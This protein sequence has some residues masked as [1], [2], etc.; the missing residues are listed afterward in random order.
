MGCGSSRPSDT[1]NP[2]D[3]EARTQTQGIWDDDFRPMPRGPTMNPP[4][5]LARP[6]TNDL[7]AD[8]AVTVPADISPTQMDLQ[9]NFPTQTYI[10]NSRNPQYPLYTHSITNSQWSELALHGDQDSQS[11]KPIP[12]GDPARYTIDARSLGHQ[13]VFTQANSPSEKSAPSKPSR[14]PQRPAAP[15]GN[16][17]FHDAYI[18]GHEVRF[19]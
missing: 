19:L 17:T 1:F 10:P 14:D 15:H 13:P 2:Q 7:R 6:P 4:L 9:M 3:Y 18:L 11:W 5:G 16:R 8:I 12:G